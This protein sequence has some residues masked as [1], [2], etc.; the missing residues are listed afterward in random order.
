MEAYMNTENEFETTYFYWQLNNNKPTGKLKSK[1]CNFYT[2]LGED[3]YIVPYHENEILKT[4]NCPIFSVR[5]NEKEKVIYLSYFFRLLP[6]EI[7]TP[8]V[9]N[10]DETEELFDVTMKFDISNGISEV[11]ENEYTFPINSKFDLIP[12]QVLKYCVKEI[13]RLQGIKDFFPLVIKGEEP[14]NT[15]YLPFCDIHFHTKKTYFSIEYLKAIIE[16]PYIPFLY[17]LKEYFENGIVNGME[18]DPWFLP[19]YIEKFNNINGLDPKSYK[20]FF[21]A[22]N[23]IPSKLYLKRVFKNLE[24][25][26]KQ[27]YIQFIRSHGVE[28]IT[29]KNE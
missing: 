25:F 1:K 24:N 14:G 12:D 10:L 7:K 23:K 13:R 17:F 26:A 22:I 8:Y 28:G 16:Y 6:E 19:T 9:T 2:E 27:L 18:N 20:E 15:L 5:T 3:V 11:F 29:W 4:C 21:R